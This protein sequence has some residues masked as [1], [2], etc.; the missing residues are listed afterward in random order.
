RLSSG[1]TRVARLA[2]PLL[3]SSRVLRSKGFRGSSSLRRLRTAWKRAAAI[4]SRA[5]RLGTRPRRRGYVRLL[6]TRRV[7]ARGPIAVARAIAKLRSAQRELLV[8]KTEFNAL[9]ANFAKMSSV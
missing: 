8:L 7:R 9:K 1:A 4:A 3:Y 5:I 6:G 2:R